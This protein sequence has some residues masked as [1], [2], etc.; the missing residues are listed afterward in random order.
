MVSG[1]K[2][3]K[4]RLGGGWAENDDPFALQIVKYC[5]KQPENVEK[6]FG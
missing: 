6:T 3:K 4:L 2:V 5:R 1:S